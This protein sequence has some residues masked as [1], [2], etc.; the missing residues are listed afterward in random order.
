MTSRPKKCSILRTSRKK[1]PK[2]FNYQLHGHILEYKSNSKY[3][4]ITINNKLCW[5]NHIDSVCKKAN[6]S[7]AFRRRNLQI[8]QTQ[9]KAGAHRTLVI[10]Q[11]EYAV[12]IWD[13]YT[14]ENQNKLEMV[15]RQA[16]RFACNNYSRQGDR[17][18]AE[19]WMAKPTDIRLALSYKCLHGLMAVD[20]SQDLVPQTCQ[21]CHSHPMAFILPYETKLQQFSA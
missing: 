18:A 1:S 12:A 16:A 3:L 20:L 15:Q 17:D 5:N 8:S 19:T 7:I 2:L 6:S 11:L 21:S 13:P 10:P 9:I 14:K 4:G